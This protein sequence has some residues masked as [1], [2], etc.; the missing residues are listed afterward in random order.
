MFRLY[1]HDGLVKGAEATCEGDR[2][3]MPNEVRRYPE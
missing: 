1:P 3:G 2:T